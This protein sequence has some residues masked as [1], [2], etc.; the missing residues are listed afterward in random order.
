[1]TATNNTAEF[2]L[3][4]NGLAFTRPDDAND[5]KVLINPAN[6]NI[7]S[8]V[9]EVKDDGDDAEKGKV[10]DRFDNDFMSHVNAILTDANTTD[11]GWT[12]ADGTTSL[13]KFIGDKRRFVVSVQVALILADKV[14]PPAP[15]VYAEND[16][17]V[18][19]FPLFITTPGEEADKARGGRRR[20]KMV[21][22]SAIH[23]TR[24]HKKPDR[25]QQ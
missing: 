23:R 2:K 22:R 8:V 20:T 6:I 17:A 25:K 10:K 15:E 19:Q 7:P 21:K 11:K 12:S 3:T 24:K 13:N 9:L 14:N 16:I 5:C 1:M 18:I 4:I